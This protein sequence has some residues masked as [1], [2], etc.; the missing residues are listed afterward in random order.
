ME[1]KL[2]TVTAY[3][4]VI[5]LLIIIVI[6]RNIKKNKKLKKAITELEKEKNL[7]ISTPILNELTKVESLVKDDKTKYKYDEWQSKFENIRKEDIPE[8]TEMLLDA[9]N[10]AESKQYK[11]LKILLS[12]IELKIYKLRE[13]TNNLL[14]EIKEITLSEE[15]NR[16]RIVI[17]KSKYRNLKL[18]YEKDMDSYKDVK[19]Q[20]ELEFENVEK[21]FQ[22]FEIV[23]ERKDYDEI[24]FI[25]KGIDEMIDHLEYVVKEIPAI[26]LMCNELIPNKIDDIS[27]IYISIK[28][29]DILD[30][31]KVLNLEDVVFELKTIINYF[32]NLYNDFDNEKIAKRKFESNMKS[33]K[34][35]LVRTDQIVSNLVSQLGELKTNYDLS[36][37]DVERLNIINK[38]VTSIKDSYNNLFDCNKNHTF[39]YTKLDKE[40]NFLIIKLSK[41]DE[42]L[43]Q[44]IYSIGSMKDDEL[45]ARE[46]LDSITKL[47]K[48]TRNRIRSYNIPIIPEEYYIQIQDASDAIKE[49]NKELNKKPINIETL[50]VRVDTA[51]DLVFKV[52]NTTNDLIKTV[53]MAEETIIYSNR[54]RGLKDQIDIGITKAEKYFN[55]GKYKKALE[56]TMETI[57]LVE[58]GIH[59]RILKAF[60]PIND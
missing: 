10:L 21:R 39:P 56:L 41:L 25:V 36:S 31:I 49:I 4:V 22:E 55:D 23:M 8:I 58:P 53:V 2:L 59:N 1:K 9:D 46:Q 52:Y 50:N 40:L 37:D 11:E 35:K 38:E 24:N 20:I 44:D 27:N 6:L 7:I 12:R 19:E 30:R 5:L 48:K 26:L 29:K 60:Q 57:D 32:D 3:I 45:R 33:F 17:L 51:R 13:K 34:S 43:D 47:L 16:E 15:K 28:I 54:Y 14:E 42:N 18:E